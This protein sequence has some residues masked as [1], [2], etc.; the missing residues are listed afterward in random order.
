MTRLFCRVTLAC[1]GALA[2]L[3]LPGCSGESPATDAPHSSRPAKKGYTEPPPLDPNNI[4]SV[5]IAS[6]EHKTLVAALKAADYVRSVA[7]P[8]PLTVFA[9]TDAAFAKLPKETLD[10]L[11]KPENVDQLK[12]V[13][14]YHVAVSVYYQKDLKDGMKLGMANLKNVRIKVINGKPT[15][16]GA[17]IIAS[18]RCSNGIVHVIDSVLVPE[19]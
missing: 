2:T 4:V 14:K 9:P 18:Q 1:L 11:M 8:G 15:V 19:Q 10:S 3:A 17:K 12:E 13:L 7:N 5:A 16:N 6:P